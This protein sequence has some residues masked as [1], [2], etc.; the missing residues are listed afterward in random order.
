MTREEFNILNSL[1]DA[2]LGRAKSTL[3]ISL[4]RGFRSKDYEQL[5]Q[6]GQIDDTTGLLTPKGM[7]ALEPYRVDSAVILAAGSAT[8]F[9]PL[10]LEQPKGLYEVRGER[11]IERQIQQ[12]QEAGV[13][14]ITIVLGYKKDMFAYLEEKYGVRLVMEVEKFNC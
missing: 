12:L 10:S 1:Y 8:R 3:D 13:R 14:D 6:A 7:E 5:V 4:G 11:L 9:I 2:S